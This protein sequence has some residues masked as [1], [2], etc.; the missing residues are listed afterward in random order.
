MGIKVYFFFF[1][2]SFSLARSLWCVVQARQGKE[3]ERG[4]RERDG[5]GGA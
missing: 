2:V 5:G 1:F 3:R 4:E